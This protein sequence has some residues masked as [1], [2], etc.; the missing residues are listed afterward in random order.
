MFNFLAGIVLG[1]L[2]AWALT[3]YG[4][5]ELWWKVKDAWDAVRACSFMESSLLANLHRWYSSA[6]FCNNPREY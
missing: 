4:A 3:K 2:A 5:Q 1:A 6:L